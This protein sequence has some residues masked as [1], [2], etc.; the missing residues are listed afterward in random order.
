M[1]SGVVLYKE[2]SKERAMA[3]TTSVTIHVY[4]DK[5]GNLVLQSA[6]LET[7]W[8]TIDE[9]PI[10][11]TEVSLADSGPQSTLASCQPADCYELLCKLDTATGGAVG[12]ILSRVF[13]AGFKAASTHSHSRA[14]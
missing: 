8:E 12:V 11:T 2:T 4:K 1:K 5:A 14:A 6:G 7:D 10:L 13:E 9:A 3:Q